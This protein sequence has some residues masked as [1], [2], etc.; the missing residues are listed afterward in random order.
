MCLRSGRADT[1]IISIAVWQKRKLRFRDVNCWLPQRI[2]I[3][4][5][6]NVRSPRKPPD[7]FSMNIPMWVLPSARLMRN[8]M[9]CKLVA[10]ATCQWIPVGAVTC[11][12][13]TQGVLVEELTKSVGCG[14]RTCWYIND[15]VPYLSIKVTLRNVP[16]CSTSYTHVS[17]IFMLQVV[18]TK[19]PPGI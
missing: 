6:S 8:S 16:L 15:E 17:Y 14:I 10:W 7:P 19:S 12:I 9:V 13:K 2:P 11:S 3:A 4:P 5:P 18:K 1:Q